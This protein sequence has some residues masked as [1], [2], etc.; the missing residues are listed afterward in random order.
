[1]RSKMKNK[2]QYPKDYVVVDIET[3]GLRANHDAILEIG[4]VKVR[5]HE[6]VDTFSDLIN[7]ECL[8]SPFI[9]NL[10]G[11]NNEMVRDCETIPFVLTR[12]LDFLQDDLIIGH[13]VSFDLGFLRNKCERFGLAELNN[14]KLDTL[15]IARKTLPHLPHHRLSDLVEYFKVD[16]SR[17]HRALDDCLATNA[18]LEHMRLLS[19]NEPLEP[20]HPLS[21][22]RIVLSGVFTILDKKVV[23]K[24]IKDLKSILQ[25]ALTSKTDILVLANLK[26]INLNE[27]LTLSNHPFQILSESDFYELLMQDLK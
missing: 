15:S 12:F 14:P 10:T 13:N 1:M 4:A 22:K 17:A 3:T 5:N 7:P 25:V 6:V 16:Q 23:S 20:S 8:I 11:I 19:T 9:T 26:G 18:I 27:T 21:H 24:R 2:I